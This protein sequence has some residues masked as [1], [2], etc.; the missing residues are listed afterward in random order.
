MEVVAR[1]LTFEAPTEIPSGWT[2]I[3]FNNQSAMVHFAMVERVPDGYGVQDQQELIAPVFQDGLDLLMAGEVDAAME[4]FGELPAW[5]G[6]IVFLGGP[7]LTAAGRTS[8]ATVYLEPGTYLLECYVKTDGIFHSFNPDPEVGGMV[9]GFTVTADSSRAP[10]PEASVHVTVSSE[11]GIEMGEPLAPGEQIVAIEFEDQT[12][13]ENFVGSDLHLARVDE[14]TDLEALAEWMDWTR[15]GG[16]ETPA[17]VVFIGGTNE[18]P[19]GTTTYVTVDLE[20]GRYAWVSEVTDP[21][22]KG[23]LKTFVVPGE[24]ASY[25]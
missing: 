23:M 10:E 13:H 4:R 21:R 11:S 20:P 18:M 5:F 9:H 16:L 17:P 24:R 14:D 25:Q 8:E 22:S 6:E 19:A 3:R 7:G 15:P 1:G 2:T 12:T